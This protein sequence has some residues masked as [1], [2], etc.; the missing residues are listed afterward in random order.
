VL[1]VLTRGA[2]PARCWGCGRE[3]KG[4]SSGRE[5]DGVRMSAV[6][7]M[8]SCLQ[9]RGQQQR[10]EEVSVD[11]RVSAGMLHFSDCRAR[12]NCSLSPGAFPRNELPGGVAYEAGPVAAVIQAVEA[13]AGVTM[14]DLGSFD[15]RT[16]IIWPAHS[17]RRASACCQALA[18]CLGSVR[19]DAANDGEGRS[20]AVQGTLLELVLA[21][22]SRLGRRVLL[23]H[24]DDAWRVVQRALA[25]MQGC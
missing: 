8:N 25:G 5:P 23:G 17:L 13:A 3:L 9:Q 4:A 24:E 21:E 15:V 20:S 16:M 1:L 6:G 14:R 18:S 7:P 12:Y 22:A 2:Y 11:G 10:R 19:S